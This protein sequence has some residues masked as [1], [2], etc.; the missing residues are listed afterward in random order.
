MPTGLGPATSPSRSPRSLSFA[1]LVATCTVAGCDT[2]PPRQPSQ[3]LGNPS[4][5]FQLPESARGRTEERGVMSPAPKMLPYSQSWGRL[6]RR[7]C[8]GFRVP[9]GRIR[10][11]LRLEGDGMVESWKGSGL[12]FCFLLGRCEKNLRALGSHS[13]S[14]WFSSGDLP[15]TQ[16]VSQST[17]PPSWLKNELE[18]QTAE[19][20]L[21][22][23]R[24]LPPCP[25]LVTALGSSSLPPPPSTQLES[26]RVSVSLMV[27]G[28]FP[29]RESK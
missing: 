10:F 18:S 24:P 9:A 11:L 26:S 16:P 20:V 8:T 22:S 13:T 2:P 12:A 14:C 7:L 28:S 27:Q 25:P 15:G 19:L 1:K 4:F 17:Q 5:I 6:I 21:A 23:G 3:A 29:D